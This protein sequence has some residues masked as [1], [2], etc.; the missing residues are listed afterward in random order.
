MSITEKYKVIPIASKITHEWLLKTHYAKRLPSISY[1]FSLI[2]DNQIMGI[3]SF[4]SPPSPPLCIGICG[5]QYK[6]MVLEL[7]RLVKRGNLENNV[8]S[9]FVSQCLKQLPQPKI[10]VSYADTSHNHNGYIYQAC[11][12]L[13]TGLSAKRTEWKIKGS[14]KHS[15]S[16]C[17]KYSLKER[18]SNPKFYLGDRPRKHRYIY[19]NGDKRI[20]KELL[21][22][23]KYPILPYP[24]QINKNYKI[25]FYPNQKLQE[26]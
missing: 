6:S 14:N 21:K 20:K 22:Q 16:I 15:K 2:L 11:N 26:A 1:A 3:C 7:N 23:L 13:Y 5:K 8:T 4:G 17:D 9:F 25:N 12:F 10:I 19:F 18:K 24:K